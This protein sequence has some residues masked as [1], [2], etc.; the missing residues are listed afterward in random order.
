MT[1]HIRGR[2]MMLMTDTTL[3]FLVLQQDLSLQ[4]SSSVVE[5]YSIEH[6]DYTPTY[7][8]VQLQQSIT[9][10][11]IV[12]KE[13]LSSLLR[14]YLNRTV[15]HFYV[16]TVDSDTRSIDNDIL[17]SASGYLSNVKVTANNGEVST[18][19][20]TIIPIDEL[21]RSRIL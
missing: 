9:G 14:Y 16:G 21:I 3:S 12:T 7:D 10:S 4:T 13:S 17:Y 20:F 18:V 6:T 8:M 5:N 1:Q 15:F 11:A 2:N 19:S